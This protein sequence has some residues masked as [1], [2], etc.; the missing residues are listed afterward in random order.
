MLRPLDRKFHTVL[1]LILFGPFRN[2]KAVYNVCSNVCKQGEPGKGCYCVVVTHFITAYYYS[3]CNN[4]NLFNKIS[5]S[6]VAVFAVPPA[7]VFQIP[8]KSP[9]KVPDRESGR[10]RH[11]GGSSAANAAA[12]A[13]EILCAKRQRLYLQVVHI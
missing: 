9:G 11:G 1:A 10:R 5:T 8:Q 4:L 13:P 2:L 6:T 7:A 12:V 3:L